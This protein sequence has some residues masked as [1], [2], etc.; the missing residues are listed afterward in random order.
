MDKL[1]AWPVLLRISIFSVLQ[2]TWRSTASVASQWPTCMLRATRSL[3]WGARGL[4]R[5]QFWS[6]FD[7]MQA[8][9]FSKMVGHSQKK[10]FWS[11]CCLAPGQGYPFR[12]GSMDTG[13]GW[14]H[15]V[16]PIAV[17]LFKGLEAAT[18]TSLII[19]WSRGTASMVWFP[20][21]IPTCTFVLISMTVSKKAEKTL[22]I[23]LAL[24]IA[25][26]KI[27]LAELAGSQDVSLSKELNGRFCVATW[28][29][30]NFKSK[31]FA[32][33]A[34]LANAAV[35]ERNLRHG[36]NETRV[37]ATGQPKK[38]LDSCSWMLV[39][40]PSLATNSTA[41]LAI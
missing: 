3:G 34:N 41:I 21:S 15:L 37:P 27:S 7:F 8:C 14:G 33:L 13:S 28:W 1:L 4:T 24:T 35:C 11:G 20:N 30:L 17:V 38:G 16:C 18:H 9:S 32:N 23:Q 29:K 12:R 39:V 19:V 10:R 26:Q 40:K 2:T 5:L 22:S 25:C 36:Q 31:E 6:G